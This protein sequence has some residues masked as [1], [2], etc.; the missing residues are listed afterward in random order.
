[1]VQSKEGPRNQSSFLLF[2]KQILFVGWFLPGFPAWEGGHTGSQGTPELTK[3]TQLAPKWFLPRSQRPGWWDPYREEDARFS[4]VAC[5]WRNG[6]T[7]VSDGV[8]IILDLRIT[9]EE[10]ST[11]CQA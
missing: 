1:M 7:G 2:Q 11:S 4:A 5:V 6:V 3:T 8:I 10:A 9:E